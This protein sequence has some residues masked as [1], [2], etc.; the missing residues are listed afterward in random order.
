MR[1]F[2][3]ALAVSYTDTDAFRKIFRLKTG[4]TPTQFRLNH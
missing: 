2:E 4:K 1:S 3:V